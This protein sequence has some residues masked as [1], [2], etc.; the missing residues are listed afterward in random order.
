M[1]PQWGP[2]VI[3]PKHQFDDKTTLRPANRRRGNDEGYH[4]LTFIEK[5][6]KQFGGEWEMF[7]EE[8]YGL[9]NTGCKKG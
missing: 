3:S 1:I 5:R 6:K 8:K 9:G 2:T 4:V 7:E